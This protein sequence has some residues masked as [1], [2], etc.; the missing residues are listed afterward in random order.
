MTAD[1]QPHGLPPGDFV[2]AD[3]QPVIIAARRTAVRRANGALK[4]L[5]AHK[6]LAPVLADL[7]ADT[8]VP[9]EAVTDVV[10]GNAVGGGGNVARLALLEAGLPVSVPGLTVDRQCGSGL[11]AIVLAARLVAAGGNL[12]YLAGGVES[13]STAPLRAYRDDDGEP[14]FFAR[15]QFV[16][17]SFGDPDMGVAAENVAARFEVSRERQDASA[18]RSHQRALAATKAG[19]FAAEITTLQTPAGPISADDGPRAG[20]SAA[21]LKRFPAAFVPEGTVTAGN[22]CF[23]ADAACA[24]V[25]TSLQRARELGAA[26]GLLV[27]GSDTAGVDPDVLGIGA[28]VAGQRLLQSRGLSADSVDLVEFNEAFASQTLACLD[29]LGID[30]ERANLDGGALALGHAYG[31]SGAVLVTR[32]L[33]QA[34]RTGNHGS[35]ALALISIAGGMGTAALLRYELLAGGRQDS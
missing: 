28:A 21:V 1:L 8:Q 2:P 35:L 17:H 15:A 19:Y 29:Q 18:L 30:P 20:L 12:V 31:A 13:I 11:D 16:P 6:L 10:I 9:A 23:D 14:A 33:A 24:V 32:L 3:R 25:I 26:D 34:R 4:E 7:L 27:L 5:R 22:S